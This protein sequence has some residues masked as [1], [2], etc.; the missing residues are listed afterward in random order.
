MTLWIAVLATAAGC[1]LLKFAGLAAPRRLLDHPA[2]SR[3]AMTVPIAL[4]AALI[5][6]QAVADGR[7]LVVDLPR[8]A[9]LGAAVLALLLR[10]PFLLVIVAAA[11]TA[12]GL[13]AL[14]AG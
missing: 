6:L 8:L 11:A 4:L 3:F 5:A 2:V 13:R 9:G 7:E 10:A 14:G 12:A 1:Y